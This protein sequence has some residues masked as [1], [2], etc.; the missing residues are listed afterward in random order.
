MKIIFKDAALERGE[1]IV[2]CAFE[3]DIVP[4]VIKAQNFVAIKHRIVCSN[5]AHEHQIVV[6]VETHQFVVIFISGVAKRERIVES[7][8]ARITTS[9]QN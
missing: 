6:N 1:L 9:A 2:Q 8:I 3:I 5:V 7:A 4:K